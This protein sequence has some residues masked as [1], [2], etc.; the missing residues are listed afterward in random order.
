MVTQK[1]KGILIILM[2]VIQY[3]VLMLVEQ[4]IVLRHCIGGNT[5]N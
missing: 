1:L 4:A 5:G 3:I 2:R